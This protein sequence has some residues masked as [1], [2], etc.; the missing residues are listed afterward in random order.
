MIEYYNRRNK[1]IKAFGGKCFKCNTKEDLQFHHK[2]QA[3]SARI[4]GFQQLRRVEK[5]LESKD[6]NII[7]L[8]H[9]CH[10]IEHHE[11]HFEVDYLTERTWFQ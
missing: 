2:H 5:S 1:L 9:D 4:G 7:L 6:N 8:C 3:N 10:I 11:L